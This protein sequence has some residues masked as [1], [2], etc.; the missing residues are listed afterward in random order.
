LI[1]TQSIA[2]LIFET[3]FQNQMESPMSNIAL[4]FLRDE[5]QPPSGWMGT[6]R[7]NWLDIAHRFPGECEC[8]ASY[9]ALEAAEVIDGIK[10]ANLINLI[11]RQH[12]CGRNI[13]QFWQRH[14][15][16]LLAHSGLAVRELVYRNDGVLILIYHPA[17]LAAHLKTPKVANFLHKAGYSR[18]TVMMQVLEALTSR[19][20]VGDF[21]H[22]IGA[23]LGYPLKD[24]AGFMGWVRLPVSH[25][26]P[27][28]MYGDPRPGLVVAAACRGCRETMASRL[29]MGINPLDCLGQ[30]TCPPLFFRDN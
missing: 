21:P 26:G 11:D 24:V 12:S 18:P 29:A 27:W 16:R 28:K 14:G 20:A 2:C 1:L 13:Y 7:P 23:L 15:K 8:L 9:L 4:S 3:D 5:Q 30:N 17:R 22:E 10:P 19:F 25:Q 6:R